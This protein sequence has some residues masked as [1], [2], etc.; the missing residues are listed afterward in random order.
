MR[1]LGIDHGER[2]VGVALSDEEGRFAQPSETVL[3]KDP[4]ALVTAIA[5][6]ARSAHVGEIVVGLP[7]TLEGREGVSAR[8]ARRFAA[9]IEEAARIPVVLWDERLTT[10]T[11]ERALDEAGVRGKDRRK[12]VDQVAAAVMLQ[13]YLDTLQARA[14]RAE[15]GALA[16][17]DAREETATEEGDEPWRT[18]EPAV[19]PRRMRG[20]RRSDRSDG[21]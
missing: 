6:L 20:R 14:E 2:R 16:D 18:S 5:E 4:K 15:R 9:L 3:R 13:S 17:H 7:L 19:A 10:V 21:R 12:V 11:A 8:R 1:R